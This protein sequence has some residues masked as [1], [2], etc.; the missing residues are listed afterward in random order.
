MSPVPMLADEDMA[1]KIIDYLGE[2]SA[3]YGTEIEYKDGIG[4]VKL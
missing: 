2:L 1:K 3:P 4:R